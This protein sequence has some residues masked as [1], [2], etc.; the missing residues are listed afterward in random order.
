MVW[1]ECD[2][3]ADLIEIVIKSFRVWRALGGDGRVDQRYT[4]GIGG[5]GGGGGGVGGL[6]AAAFAGQTVAQYGRGRHAIARVVQTVKVVY[7][8][9]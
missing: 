5:G 3:C 4:I 1:C 6:Y 2:G 9:V 8:G 7:V